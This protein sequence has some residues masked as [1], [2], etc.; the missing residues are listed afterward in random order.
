MTDPF[1]ENIRTN[2]AP[3]WRRAMRRAIRAASRD[4]LPYIQKAP[5]HAGLY[6]IR[7][8][9]K[10]NGIPFDPLN[11]R[12]VHKVAAMGRYF[13]LIAMVRQRLEAMKE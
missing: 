5:Y 2:R 3:R 8:F 1:R 11:A 10:V 12:H 6:A 9:E 7:E 4:I 13:R